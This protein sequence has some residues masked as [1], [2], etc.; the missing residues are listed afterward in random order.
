MSIEKDTRSGDFNAPFACGLVATSTGL[1]LDAMLGSRKTLDVFRWWI[2]LL[3]SV[4][5]LVLLGAA[6]WSVM[7]FC[8]MTGK[9]LF[10]RKRVAEGPQDES[11]DNGNE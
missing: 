3:V 2:P 1:D 4:N 6:F 5:V 7:I 11:P 8:S 10:K 9:R